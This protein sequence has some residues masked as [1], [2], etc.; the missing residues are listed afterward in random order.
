MAGVGGFPSRG[1]WRRPA[2][3]WVDIVVGAAIVALLYG[4]LRLAPSQESSQEC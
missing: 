2:L 1:V 4:L 3:R